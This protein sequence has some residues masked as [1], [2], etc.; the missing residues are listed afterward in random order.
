MAGLPHARFSASFRLPLRRVST[1]KPFHTCI[2]VTNNAALRRPP[3]P[4]QSFLGLWRT[5]CTRSFAGACLLVSP[6]VD[7]VAVRASGPSHVH[8]S[9]IPTPPKSALPPPPLL[10][11]VLPAVPV[12]T[13]PKQ[14]A[15]RVLQYFFGCRSRVGG[16]VGF[17][18]GNIIGLVKIP[19]FWRYRANLAA[20]PV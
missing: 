3:P 2:A 7:D 15:Q 18:V 10:R 20:V 16:M 9:G 12:S 6:R 4:K 11:G 14:V 13:A 17:F 19:K 8:N 1:Q 5:K